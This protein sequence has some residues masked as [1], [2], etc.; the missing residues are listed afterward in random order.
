VDC[1]EAF[2][3]E[4]AYRRAGD[5]PPLVLVHSAA[6]DGRE[7]T[8]QIEG[9]ADELSV[10]AWDEPGAGLSSTLPADFELDDYVRC[11]AAVIEAVGLGPAHVGGISWGGMLAQRLYACRPELVATLILADTYAGWKGSLPEP[12]RQ[13]RIAR[14]RAVLDGAADDLGGAFPGLFAAGPAPELATLVDE[15]AADVRPE[16]VRSMLAMADVDL[17]A[18]LA[19]IAVPTLLVW[20][21][22]DVRSPLRIARQFEQA[23]P[24]AELVVIP[25]A[26]HLSN[27]ERPE[28]FTEAVREFCRAHPPHSA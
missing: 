4:I 3:L 27:L 9:L 10:V 16:S 19:A 6:S 5:G 21:E 23:I 14:L 7:W 20:G 1:V 24:G 18:E 25:A 15:I 22:D 2:G 12:E 17:R 11:L 28:A 26:G 13:A 8:P